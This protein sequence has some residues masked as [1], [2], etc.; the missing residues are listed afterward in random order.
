MNE[1]ETKR[2]ESEYYE[3]L[4]T[5]LEELFRQRVGDRFYLEITANK[6]FSDKL[7][8]V[9]PDYRNII[10]VF[11]KE[12]SPDLTGFVE[13]QYSKDFVTVEFKRNRIKLDEVYQTRK[14]HDLF[15]SKFTFLISLQPIPEEIKRLHKTA[16]GLL[17]PPS[18]YHAFVLAQFDEDTGSFV[19]WYPENPFEKDLY[20]R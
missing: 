7:K 4:K 11:L 18:I 12:A 3:A 5:K 19:E 14:Y 2:K 20:W 6:V 1:V 8:A 13:Q 15:D 10:Y 9:I 16:Y 17:Q